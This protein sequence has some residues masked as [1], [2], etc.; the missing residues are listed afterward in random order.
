MR[1]R[2]F[3]LSV[4]FFRDVAQPHVLATGF[5]LNGKTGRNGKAGVGHLCQTG[6]F[7]AELVLHFA[8]AIGL[9]AAEEVKVFGCALAYWLHFG[10]RESCS[11]HMSPF[12]NCNRYLS[13][14]IVQMR[15][16]NKRLKTVL[17]NDFHSII[18]HQAGLSSFRQCPSLFPSLSL[19]NRRWLR[20]PLIT[21]GA[22]QAG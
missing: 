11:C 12:L 7:A 13:A 8:V 5:S 4:H 14:G 17:L 19:K 2:L 15:T 10:F 18:S 16:A 20:I 21:F 6:T 1:Q 22:A 9:A 3:H